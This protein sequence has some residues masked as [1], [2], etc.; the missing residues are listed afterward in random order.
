MRKRRIQ[1]HVIILAG[2][3]TPAADRSYQALLRHINLLDERARQSDLNPSADVLLPG[4]SSFIN[5]SLRLANASRSY[6]QASVRTGGIYISRTF[7][8]GRITSERQSFRII[9]ASG[10][11]IRRIFVYQVRMGSKIS[12]GIKT[13]A[14]AQEV[15][16]VGMGLSGK[17]LGP[18]HTVILSDESLNR[19]DGS[20]TM[21]AGS[22]PEHVRRPSC[23]I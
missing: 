16:R 13:Q 10:R 21:A 2:W 5:L 7:R 4:S 11:T 20:R 14:P 17:D 23:G 12:R 1:C 9:T 8:D 15:Q 19:S 3:S 18:S 22:L 6:E